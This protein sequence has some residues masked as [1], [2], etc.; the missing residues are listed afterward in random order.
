MQTQRGKE[1]S[2]R[3]KK[4]KDH[5]GTEGITKLGLKERGRPKKLFLSSDREQ[6]VG[7]YFL[8]WREP[9]GEESSIERLTSQRFPI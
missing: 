1:L 3:L 5:V 8:Y 6:R 4:W 7:V 9:S 2:F